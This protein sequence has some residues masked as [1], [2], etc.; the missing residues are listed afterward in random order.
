MIR[1]LLYAIS[2]RLPCRIINDGD[3]PYLERYYV[4]RAF[5]WTFY[6]HRFVASDPERGLHDHPWNRAYSF[7]LAG[8][9]LEVTRMGSRWVRWF[10]C[11]NGESFHRVMVLDGANVWTLFCHGPYVKPWGFMRP[12][13]TLAGEELLLWVP[14]AYQTD[15][16]SGK[17]RWWESAPHGVDEHRRMPA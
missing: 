11:L 1:R 5:G 8:K 10:N 14:H 2:G 13:E 12:L 16:A 7:V 15:E 9:Y 4:G 3:R 17:Q 6:L